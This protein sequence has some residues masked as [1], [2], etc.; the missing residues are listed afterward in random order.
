MKPSMFLANKNTNKEIISDS[1]K[2]K[3]NTTSNKVLI[4]EKIEIMSDEEKE[5]SADLD[6]NKSDKT[7][8][9]EKTK[10]ITFEELNAT[11]DAVIESNKEN[12]KK[13]QK[14]LKQVQQ[15]K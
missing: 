11:F 5:T 6:I 3:N 4:P 15:T 14:K 13:P 9:S 2:T 1:D 12:N 8:K 7:K 10:T